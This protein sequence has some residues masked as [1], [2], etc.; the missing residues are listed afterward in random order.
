[1]HDAMSYAAAIDSGISLS[2]YRKETLRALGEGQ[3]QGRLD[4][5]VWSK[6][7]AARM[8]L[9]LVTLDSGDKALCEARFERELKGE[10][11]YQG[12]LG[13]TPGQAVLVTVTIGPRGGV[14]THLTPVC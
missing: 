7:S 9:A 2:G 4:A 10:P 13:S 3:Y 5:L 14:H 8:L 11:K 1:M 12:F 6:P